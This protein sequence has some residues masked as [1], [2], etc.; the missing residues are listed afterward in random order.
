MEFYPTHHIR[1]QFWA[2]Y[3]QHLTISPPSTISESVDSIPFLWYFVCVST[4]ATQIQPL[5]PKVYLSPESHRQTN[6]NPDNTVLCTP[7]RVVQTVGNLRQDRVQY[8][9]IIMLLVDYSGP[10]SSTTMFFITIN[11]Q[12][13]R[14]FDNFADF[15]QKNNKHNKINDEV[16]HSRL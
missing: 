3:Q 16:K 4:A 7:W 9:T 6:R 13:S 14:V 15:V 8:H 2:S 1:R 12:C 10:P 5:Q 11:W